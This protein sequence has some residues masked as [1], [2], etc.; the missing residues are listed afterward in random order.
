MDHSRYLLDA[1]EECSQKL[2]NVD[3]LGEISL[4]I[5][6]KDTMNAAQDPRPALSPMR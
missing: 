5:N 6:R 3:T 1:E 4:E 2:E